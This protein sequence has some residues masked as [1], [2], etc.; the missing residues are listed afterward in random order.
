MLIKIIRRIISIGILEKSLITGIVF[1]Y[2]DFKIN[3]L[4]CRKSDKLF[5][6]TVLKMEKNLL[7]IFF[8][9][10]F[11]LLWISNTWE[12]THSRGFMR[13]IYSLISVSFLFLFGRQKIHL[14]LKITAKFATR[15]IILFKLKSERKRQHNYIHLRSHSL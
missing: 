14:D 13:S 4:F 12:S 9:Q 11:L 1:I 10:N 3:I 15:V 8:S 5:K 2:F 6:I 7:K